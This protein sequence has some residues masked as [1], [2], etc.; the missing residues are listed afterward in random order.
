VPTA[1]AAVCSEA[2]SL[3]SQANAVLKESRLLRDIKA[4]RFAVVFSDFI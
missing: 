3:V 1:T 4:K 2:G